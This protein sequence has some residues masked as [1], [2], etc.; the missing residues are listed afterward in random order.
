M[1]YGKLIS[2]DKTSVVASG[3]AGGRTYD[4]MLEAYPNNHSFAP[5]KSNILVRHLFHSI[6]FIFVR[7]CDHFMLS[8]ATYRTVP[9]WRGYGSGLVIAALIGVVGFLN[10]LW[11]GS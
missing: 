3:L 11:S 4:V 2:P 8:R 9:I 6:T 7:C 1:S 10:V 5:H